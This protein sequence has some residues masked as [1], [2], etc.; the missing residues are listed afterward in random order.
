ML[1]GGG[2]ISNDVIPLIGACR[3]NVCLHLHTF[4]PR[5]DWRKSESTVDG[6][7]QGNWRRNSN[8]RDVVASSPSFSS[9]AARA[10]LRAFS[11]A[12]PYKQTKI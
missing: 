10:P 2:D 1:I 6:E 7:P 3:V 11:Q 5:A 8:R 12:N 9:P 4:P